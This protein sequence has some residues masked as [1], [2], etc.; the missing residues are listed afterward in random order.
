MIQ[1]EWMM[2]R[3][4]HSSTLRVMKIKDSVASGSFISRR[5]IR[6][7]LRALSPRE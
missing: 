3:L 1:K 7:R 6:L 4:I 2:L 5:H